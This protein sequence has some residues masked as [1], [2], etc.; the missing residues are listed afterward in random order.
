MKNDR[1]KFLEN[2]Q[3]TDERLEKLKTLF[4]EAFADGKLNIE[5]LKDL[6]CD[7]SE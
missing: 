3:T 6:C 5:A 4:P 7:D 1:E 2:T